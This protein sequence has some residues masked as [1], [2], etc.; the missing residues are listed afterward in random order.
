MKLRQFQEQI[1][2]TSLPVTADLI[3]DFK[4]IILETDQ[5]KGYPS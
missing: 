1:S 4:A 2:K 3:N 5:R